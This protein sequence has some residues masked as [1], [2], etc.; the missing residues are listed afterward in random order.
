MP[1]RAMAAPAFP[2]DT[3]ALVKTAGD[4][5]TPLRIVEATVAGQRRTASAPWA[6][7]SSRRWAAALRGKIVAM[8]GLTFKPNTDDMREAP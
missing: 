5:D 2:K 4:A 8:L 1:A 7:R 6:A 3:L